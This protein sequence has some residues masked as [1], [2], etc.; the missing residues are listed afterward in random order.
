MGVP[1]CFESWLSAGTPE[2][3]ASN[4]IHLVKG[5]LTIAIM[6]ANA[7]NGP[8]VGGPFERKCR[9]RGQYS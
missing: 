5:K 4:H 3:G 8:P 1:S 2:T 9:N 6:Q 7:K